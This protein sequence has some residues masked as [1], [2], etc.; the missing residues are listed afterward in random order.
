[1]SLKR[2]ICAWLLVSAFTLFANDEPVQ[3]TAREAAMELLNAVEK[4]GLLKPISPDQ[5]HEFQGILLKLL[6]VP[7]SLEG[8]LAI[9]K[10]PQIQMATGNHIAILAIPQFDDDISLELKQLSELLAQEKPDAL[11]LDLCG[12]NGD[13]RESVQQLLDYLST[14]TTPVAVLFDGRTRGLA[15]SMLPDLTERGC[16]TFGESSAGLP[17]ARQSIPLAGETVLKYYPKRSQPIAPQI[18][19]T[20]TQDHAK[21]RQVAA[22]HIRIRMITSKP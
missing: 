5:V 22:D 12:S 9:P 16:L 7:A 6:N 19:L 11:L 20:Q 18:S 3:P 13:S 4:T 17:D 10:R 2:H 1:M 14:E 8:E 21:W 15:E